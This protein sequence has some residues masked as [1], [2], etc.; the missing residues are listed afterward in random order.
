M[1]RKTILFDLDGTLWDSYPWY[2]TVAA[3]LLGTTADEVLAQLQ[4]GL[5][6]VSLVTGGG[7]E[8]ADFKRRCARE[9]GHLLLYDGVVATLPKLEE[10]G[11]AMGIVTSL[12][13]WLAE[14]MLI[15]LELMQFFDAVEYRAR[16]PS[17]TGI[18]AALRSLDE[19]PHNHV[20]YIGDTENDGG[21]A[22]S[23]EVKFGWASYGYGSQKPSNC[24]LLLE[25]FA[26]V[27]SV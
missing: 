7:V 13:K 3:N 26:D 12:P 19:Q 17:P 20:F 25:T 18:I 21:A 1:A 11:V 6:I 9:L 23:A 5:S 24:A 10:T 27:L 8:R 16:K 15:G 4:K 2:A 14:P 22:H